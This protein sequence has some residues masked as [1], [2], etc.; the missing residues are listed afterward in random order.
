[1]RPAYHAARQPGK[2]SYV[3]AVGAVCRPGDYLVQEDYLSLP[4]FYRHVVVFYAGYSAGE[5]C[6]FKVMRCKQ[7]FRAAARGI[8]SCQVFD[9]GARYGDAVVG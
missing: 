4:F 6:Q 9:G 7:Y 1:V 2:L 5:V 8:F 3:Y